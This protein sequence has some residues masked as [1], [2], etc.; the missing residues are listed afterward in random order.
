MEGYMVKSISLSFIGVMLFIR[1]FAPASD[2][3]AQASSAA[4]TGTGG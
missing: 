4:Q 1:V 3:E 2:R